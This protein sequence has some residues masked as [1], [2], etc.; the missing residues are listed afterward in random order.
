M[1]SKNCK[2]LASKNGKHNVL[3]KWWAKTK[4][5]KCWKKL[6]QT[7]QEQRGWC[8]WIRILR[9]CPTRS[10]PKRLCHMNSSLLS[11]DNKKGFCWLDMRNLKGPIR[12]LW[13]RIK[14]AA[15]RRLWQRRLS[16]FGPRL[17]VGCQIAKG[18]P[19]RGFLLFLHTQG[20][21]TVSQ[22][23]GNP[24]TGASCSHGA[25]KKKQLGRSSKC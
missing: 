18:K 15:C 13:S 19:A 1:E 2:Y 7:K 8:S 16:I 10:T 23:Q 24:V 3:Q 22:K 6:K 11:W 5:I 9:P 12:N 4:N 14:R 20:L 21:R 25:D 17:R